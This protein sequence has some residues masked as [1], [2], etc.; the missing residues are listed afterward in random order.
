MI[1]FYIVYCTVGIR[2]VYEVVVGVRGSSFFPNALIQLIGTELDIS[3]MRKHFLQRQQKRRSH[4]YM[5][6]KLL[7]PWWT[8]HSFDS[9]PATKN[10]QLSNYPMGRLLKSTLYTTTVPPSTTYNQQQRF[11]QEAQEER[12]RTWHHEETTESLFDGLSYVLF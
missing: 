3:A 5:T 2:A 12:K 8:N 1:I 6:K 4:Y 9:H 11:Q 10:N 7:A